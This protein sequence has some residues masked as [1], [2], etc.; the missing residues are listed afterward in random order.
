S[1]K[2]M[3][4]VMC[5]N[6]TMKLPQWLIVAGAK[7]GPTSDGS[8]WQPDYNNAVFLEKHE[9]LIKALAERYDGH[10]YVDHVDIGSVGRW[11]EW[12]TSEMPTLVNRQKIVDLYL[13]NFKKT[14]LIMLIGG[15]ESLAYAIKNGAGWRADCWGDMGG[16]SANWNHMDDSYQQSLDAAEA[17]DA[18]KTGPVIFETCWT[19]KYWY[20]RRWD[21]DHILSEALRWHV[22]GCNNSSEDIP[23]EWWDKVVEFEKKMGYRFVLKRL[24]HPSGVKAGDSLALHMVWENKGVAPIYLQHPLA[25]EFRPVQG[26]SSRVAETGVDITRW[27]PGEQDVEATVAV[28]EDLPPGDYELGIAMLDPH[29]LEPA[30]KFA[31]QGVSSDGWYRLSRVN[32]R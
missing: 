28:P 29:S 12:H 15:D 4:R 10:P 25:I 23:E 9:Q 31:I 13:D 2:I 7:G 19:M 21:I 22:T 24:E 20:E 1:Q 14:P 5:Q 26:D 27:L 17:N 32:I 30:I 16:F 18:W 6:G 8:S 11:G 3:F